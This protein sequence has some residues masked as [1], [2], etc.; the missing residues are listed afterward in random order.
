MSSSFWF[1]LYRAEVP[2]IIVILNHQREDLWKTGNT[3]ESRWVQ[4]GRLLIGTGE[5]VGLK[6]NRWI[7]RLMLP[8]HL[9]TTHTLL[10]LLLQW[11][12]SFILQPATYHITAYFSVQ[13]SIY[14]CA[15]NARLQNNPLIN[16]YYCHLAVTVT[17]VTF[18]FILPLKYN[19][20]VMLCMIM[21]SYM[22][23]PTNVHFM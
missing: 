11:S 13:L 7:S 19:Y 23:V 22:P 15:G 14:S 17:F 21:L 9:H 5:W 10:I 20:C 16:F 4:V 12:C 8:S 2:V 18:G 1:H 3:R 6:R